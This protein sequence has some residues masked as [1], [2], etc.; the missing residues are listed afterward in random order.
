MTTWTR[1]FFGFW[2]QSWSREICWFANLSSVPG[3]TSVW[4]TVFGFMKP[5]N[6]F[7][8]YDND[9]YDNEIYCV[10]ISSYRCCRCYECAAD[11]CVTED[12]LGVEKQCKAEAQVCFVGVGEFGN[13][14]TNNSSKGLETELWWQI[15]RRI[16]QRELP[17]IFYLMFQ[18]TLIQEYT[19]LVFWIFHGWLLTVIATTLI[20]T[21]IRQ[22][23]WL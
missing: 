6:F 2:Q 15:S 18:P 22:W 7:R 11:G 23:Y 9:L 14:F 19:C 21:M 8:C 1:I 5:L 12:D 16:H 13:D 17:I 10:C 20:N 4:L 3:V